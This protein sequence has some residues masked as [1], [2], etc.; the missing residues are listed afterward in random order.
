MDYSSL[1]AFYPSACAHYDLVSL[2]GFASK[3]RDRSSALS[4]FVYPEL[5]F[6][7]YDGGFWGKETDQH[8]LNLTCPIG[9]FLLTEPQVTAAL[10]YL[11]SPDTIDVDVA[12]ENA[13]A[14]LK[15]LRFK[16]L[17]IDNFLG[18]QD[19]DA[20]DVAKQLFV[21]NEVSCGENRKRIDLLLSWRNSRNEKCAVI[22][23][24]KI[25]HKLTSDQLKAY[26][27]YARD[28][29]KPD[30]CA[31]VFLHLDGDYRHRNVREFKG[32]LWSENG[33][34]TV[35]RRWERKIKYNTSEPSQINL[36]RRAVWE[37]VDMAQRSS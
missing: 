24:A 35:M 33:W 9:G 32:D 8:N 2:E 29:L 21:A 15:A 23:E 6:G 27:T 13:S 5:D 11:L 36:L 3:F 28:V 30:R 18:L 10:K 19:S 1:S 37:S 25:G 7:F 12:Y 22:I 16:T 31:F 26:E 4:E 20:M 34:G 17:E 14:F